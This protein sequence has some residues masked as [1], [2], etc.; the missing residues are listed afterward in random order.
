MYTLHRLV[1]AT[2]GTSNAEYVLIF[3]I[4][5]TTVLLSAIWFGG[6]V[7]DATNQSGTCIETSGSN[8]AQP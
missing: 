7:G 2:N 4:V 5:G 8:C 3:A 6:V 1:R